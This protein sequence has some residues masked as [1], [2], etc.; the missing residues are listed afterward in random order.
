[1]ASYDSIL[2]TVA[3]KIVVDDQGLKQNLDAIKRDSRS[4]FSQVEQAQRRSTSTTKQAT[5][6]TDQ[7]SDAVR[8]NARFALTLRRELEAGAISEADFR[9]EADRLT[10]E[11]GDQARQLDR[12][13][14]EYDQALLGQ[15][16]LA[17]AT[18]TLEGRT[19]KLGISANIATGSFKGASQALNRF[20]PAGRTASD[21]LGLAEGA[22]EKFRS[23]LDLSRDGLV[24]FAGSL[25]TVAVVAPVFA[26]AVTGVAGAALFRLTNRSAEAADA[27][28][29]GAQAA[30]LSIESYQE[31]RFAFQQSGINAE[32]F[33][34]AVQSLN[35]RLGLAAQGNKTYADVYRTLGIEIRNANGEVRNAEDVL[36]ERTFANRLASWVSSS[37]VTASLAS[38]S[39]ATRSRRFAISS[40]RP[41]LRSRQAS[42]RSFEMS[43]SRSC[44]TPSSR[45]SRGRHPPSETWLTGS[46]KRTMRTSTS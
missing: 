44:R 33:D 2:E 11:L 17:T 12:T 43:S 4:A 40:R 34:L 28:D 19:S 6:A 7:L 5:Q 23:P 41:G 32:R 1:M 20:G 39:T 14:K 24:K 26:A 16:R 25:R 27:I 42:C 21:A 31:L 13:S 29:K 9:K 46:G 45:R 38:L 15:Q 35:R 30:G 18:A 3:I 8:Q 22:L 37:A 10:K 36:T